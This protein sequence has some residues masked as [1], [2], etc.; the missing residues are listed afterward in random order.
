MADEILSEKKHSGTV[1]ISSEGKF[2]FEW[3]R[4]HALNRPRALDY[5][6]ANK[7]LTARRIGSRVLISVAVP[8]RFSRSEHPARL[9]GRSSRQL[10]RCLEESFDKKPPSLSASAPSA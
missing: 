1:A 4:R 9:A 3:K 5:L 7:L 2:L 10:N 6:A 8:R